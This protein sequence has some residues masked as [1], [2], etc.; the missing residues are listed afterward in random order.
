MRIVAAA[1][2]WKGV[3]FTG[4]RHGEIIAQLVRLR[5]VKDTEHV[6]AEVQGFVADNGVY[7]NRERARLY[8]ITAH[9]IKPDHGTLYSED[10]W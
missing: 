5:L 8:A 10:L 4:V 3:V 1:I 6:T 9:Q 7:M 2:K